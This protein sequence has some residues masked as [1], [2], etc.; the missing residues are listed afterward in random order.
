MQ[1]GTPST[2]AVINSNSIN[3]TVV[4]HDANPCWGSVGDIWTIFAD[5]T[6]L[7]VNG[8]NQ[9]TGIP[10][11]RT[12]GANPWGGGTTT[13][14]AEGASLIV[15]YNSGGPPREITIYTGVGTTAG[16][17]QTQTLNFSA[18]LGTSAKTTYIVADGQL[19]GNYAY[20]NGTLI[21]SNA[22]PGSDPKVSTIPWSSGNLFD[23]KTYNVTVGVGGTSVTVRTGGSSDCLTWIGQVI[24]VEAE[25]VDEPW[26]DGEPS[27]TVEDVDYDVDYGCGQE[28]STDYDCDCDP[29]IDEWQPET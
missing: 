25:G 23:T 28:E 20:W 18:A 22:F 1:I 8:V 2:G 12:D 3:G 6:S 19:S 5:V 4:G 21:D 11:G 16:G 7:V 9:I 17:G 26:G 13:P 24:S 15:V 29:D 27:G 10:S 14:L